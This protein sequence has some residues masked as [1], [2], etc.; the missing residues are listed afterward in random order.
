MT[1]AVLHRHRE[2]W[3]KKPILRQLYAEWYRDIV[4][5]L[6]PGQTVEVGGGTGNL[7][8]YVS[9]VCCTD[10]VPL[11]WLDVAA[12]AQQL[13]FQSDSLANLVLFDALHHIENVSMFFDEA[14]RSLKVGGRII[15]MDP[16]V[17]WVSWPVYQ[18]LHSEQVDCKEDPLTLK[19]PQPGRQPFDSNQAVPTILFEQNQTGFQARYPRLVVQHIRRM[20]FWVY[21]LSGGF[22]HPSLLP[23][24]L[25]TPML[26]LEQKMEWFGR[27]FAFRML[28]VVERQS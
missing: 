20:A 6:A 12:D 8:E 21:P 14:Q 5:W 25:V 28:V 16:Y 3:R 26:R 1:D 10:V 7:K 4:A 27:L 22:D 17:S 23:M 9:G 24:S 2:V 18:W 15:I 19:T 13:P 11:P